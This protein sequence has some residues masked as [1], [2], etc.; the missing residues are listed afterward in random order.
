MSDRARVVAPRSPARLLMV[1]LAAVIAGFYI[2]RSVAVGTLLERDAIAEVPGWIVP[3]SG[4]VMIAA[5]ARPGLAV[6]PPARLDAAIAAIDRAPLRAEP[7]FYAGLRDAAHGDRTSARRLMLEARRRD[8]RATGARSWLLGD[9]VR[10]ARYDDAIAETAALLTLRGEQPALFQ[11]LTLIAGTPAG[12][13]ALARALAARPPWRSSY[14]LSPQSAGLPATMRFRV[15]READRQTAEQAALLGRLMAAGDYDRAYLAWVNF[16]PRGA[17]GHVGN[18]YDADFAGLPGPAPFNWTLSTGEEGSAEMS[19]PAES[20]GGTFL[21]VSYFGDAPQRLA[22]QSMVLVPGDYV[23]SVRARGTLAP[24]TGNFVWTLRCL[25]TGAVRGRI[26]ID[27]LAGAFR[28]YAAAVTIPGDCRA[29][30]L[31]LSGT[32]GESTGQNSAQFTSVSLER[33]S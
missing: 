18:V 31:E 11:V 1:L 26:E 20:R 16:L 2:V 5:A 30:E 23:L 29:Q 15:A 10:L 3:P 22:V 32:P 7:F 8:P 33:T 28:R 24:R 6:P 27:A 9:D 12:R 25:A 13:D 19:S 21:D 14:L 17:L 4:A